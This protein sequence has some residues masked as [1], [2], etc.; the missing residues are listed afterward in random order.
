MGQLSKD[1]L[2]RSIRTLL[3]TTKQN[4]NECKNITLC[5]GKILE[6][7]IS[8]HT[9]PKEEELKIPEGAEKGARPEKISQR[10]EIA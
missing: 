5:F 8:K 2:E 3:R 10:E 1:V 9:N 4:H 6:S 7:S